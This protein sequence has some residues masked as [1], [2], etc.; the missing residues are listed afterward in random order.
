[1]CNELR[2]IAN[3]TSAAVIG[4]T[5][6]WIDSSVT[7][8]EISI[9][10]HTVLRKDRNIKNNIAFNQRDDLNND[11]IETLFVDILLP[12]SKPIVVGVC[13]R[14]EP[15][16]LEFLI[17]FEETVSKIRS[18]CEV[19]IL[20]DFNINTLLPV[21][22]CRILRKYLDVLNLFHLKNLIKEPTRFPIF[23]AVWITFFVT[24][25]TKSASQVQYVLA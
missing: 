6:T 21:N 9:D 14:P 18:D 5:E 8:S 2:I 22:S 13:Y 1:M 20:G 10:G 19:T 15:E 3:K 12:R 4:L 25:Q 11:N 24:I 16:D 7:N 23:S 17:Q